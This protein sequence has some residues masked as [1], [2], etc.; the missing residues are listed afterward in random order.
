MYVCFHVCVYMYT[1]VNIYVCTYMYLVKNYTCLHRSMCLCVA[2]YVIS[3]WL[4]VCTHAMMQVYV[5]MYIND[6]YMM[7]LHVYLGIMCLHEYV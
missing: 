7:Y 3:K 4:R 6:V 5:C 1:Y 2:I